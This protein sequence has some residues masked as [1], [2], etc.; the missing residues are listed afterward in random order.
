M[1]P[2]TPH[3]TPPR[4]LSP[5]E[6]DA[7]LA[8]GKEAC[9]G[10]I[11]N[12]L[13]LAALPVHSKIQN[14]ATASHATVHHGWD[15][16]EPNLAAY[17]AT[18]TMEASIADLCDFFQLDSLDHTN[19][20]ATTASPHLK[21]RQHL[22]TV[23]D[24]REFTGLS[25]SI[26]WCAQRVMPLVASRDF[27]FLEYQTAVDIQ[28]DVRGHRKGWIRCLHS[29]DIADCPPLPGYHRARLSRSGYLVLET[30]TPGLVEVLSVVVPDY[31]AR[32]P[33]WIVAMLVQRQLAHALKIEEFMA[34]ER[35]VPWL[36]DTDT[37]D[38]VRLSEFTQSCARCDQPFSWRR[39]RRQCRICF[40]TICKACG[41]Q[42]KV[43]SGPLHA[44]NTMFVCTHCLCPK[45]SLPRASRTT[46]MLSCS[47]TQ[48]DRLRQLAKT[49]DGLTPRRQLQSQEMAQLIQT[50]NELVHLVHDLRESIDS[51]YFVK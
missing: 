50:T 23:Q 26:V 40:K 45:D 25:A 16:H 36:E 33:S 5:D 37:T 28:D 38:I 8:L 41:T 2:P 30:E 14:P 47:D 4:T 7:F 31:G 42:W 22:F 35:L 39:R 10:L 1:K 13:A 24:C 6:C 20:Y 29:V 43:P 51:G 46:M 11:E 18:S 21:S 32:L 9:L 15:I 44:S 19:A 49:L 3:K 17:C 12:A 27:C 34:K 48:R